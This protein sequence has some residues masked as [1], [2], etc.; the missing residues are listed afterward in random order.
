MKRI[1]AATVVSLLAT[2]AMIAATTQQ[3]KASD[4]DDGEQADKSRELNLSDHFAFRSPA[5]S[6]FLITPLATKSFERFSGSRISATTHWYSTPGVN[7][8]P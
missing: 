7:F 1:L 8:T 3:S 6:I 5:G 2:G 4:H